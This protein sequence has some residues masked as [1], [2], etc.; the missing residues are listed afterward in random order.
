MSYKKY[1]ISFANEKFEGALKRITRQVSLLN[2]F[3]V[4]KPYTDKEL[5]S[6]TE[7]WERHG[8]FVKNNPRGHGY[9]IW[10]SYLTLKT[11]EEMNDGDVLMYAD[12]GCEINYEGIETLNEFCEKVKTNNKGFLSFQ[13]NDLIYHHEERWTKMDLFHHFGV[14]H[15]RPSLQLHSTYFVLEKCENTMKI[16]NM[17]YF[18]VH[19][20]HF[21]DDSPSVAKNDMYFYEHRHDQ[22]VFSI[23]R[24]MHETYY[25]LTPRNLLEAKYPFIDKRNPSHKSVLYQKKTVIQTWT[26]NV[27][28]LE[29]NDV[30]NFWELG[31][32]IRGT[33][34]LYQLSKKMNFELI[35]DIQNHPISKF[36]KCTNTKYKDLVKNNANNIDFVI[37]GELENYIES[38]ENDII[39]LL[40][41]DLCDVNDIDD[42][43]KE[44][45][46]N[47]FTP[48]DFFKEY[49]E[50]KKEDI[51]INEYNIMHFRLGDDELVRRNETKF[52]NNEIIE[53]LNKYREPNDILIS[54]SEHFKNYVEKNVEIEM[55][56]T[57]TAH[58]GYQ[59]RPTE[60]METLFELFLIM[61]AKRIKTYSVYTWISGFVYWIHKIYDI[62]LE[63][64]L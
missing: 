22:S 33:V 30:E 46:K 58:F 7:F 1:F 59:K 14:E 48:T 56:N 55:Y 64:I 35:V 63:Q 53:K 5:E 45:I 18:T 23:I 29:K 41:N 10:K 25:I 13:L 60:I 27:R 9:W 8:E 38:N 43:C 54:D 61:D 44:F 21:I 39:M 51:P 6:F 62:P 16:V 42:E 32:L 47:I 24:K 20:Y 4:I 3:D 15:Y 36:L 11:L 52:E 49:I 57:R 50:L 12:A 19:N 31:D 2:Y 34:K 17:W 26:Q 40:T 28:N 37:P